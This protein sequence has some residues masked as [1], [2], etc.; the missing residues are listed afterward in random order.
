MKVIH[1]VSDTQIYL[2]ELRITS[3]KTIGF[4]PTM[5]ALHDGHI[6]LVEQSVKNNDITVVSVFVNP[7]QFNDKSDFEN[8]PVNHQRD[9]DLLDKAGC[10]LVFLPS[11]DD[12]YKNFVGFNMDFN[13]L[14]KIYEG[15]FRPGHFQG[16]VD[17]VYRLFEIVNPHKAYF[18]QKDF[19]QLAIIKLMTKLANF[20]IEIVSCPIVREKSGLAMSSRNLRLSQE[21]FKNAA[22]IYKLLIVIANKLKVGDDTDK[23]CQYFIDEIEKISDMKAE[24]CVFCNPESLVSVK[25]INKNSEIIMCVAVWC[26]KIR[27]IDNIILVF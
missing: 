22:N 21:Q 7:R 26:G 8:Y 15:E 12:I 20:D 16:V 6:S 4:I 10:N 25:K 24:Y 18:G 5:G 27:L 3:N 19:Q 2:R 14:D 11:A 1:N 13:G 23:H 17:I 9:L